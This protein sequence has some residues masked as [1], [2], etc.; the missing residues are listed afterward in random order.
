MSALS[1]FHFLRPEWLWLLL[2]LV[3][4]LGVLWRRSR[5]GSGWSQVISADLLPH[6]MEQRLTRRQKLPL[7]ALALGWLA[8]TLALAGPS[9]EKLPQPVQ[10]KQDAL[11][12]LLDLSLSVLARDIQPSRL[13]RSRLKLLDLLAQRSEGVTALVAWAGDAHVVSP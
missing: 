5:A 9:W 13:E 1:Q 10:K 2:P 4:L 11:V 7:A 3:L 8:A 12:I 6:L